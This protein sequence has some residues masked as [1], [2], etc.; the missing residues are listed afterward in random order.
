LRELAR[1]VLQS[2][3]SVLV[4]ATF[5]TRSQRALFLAL[6]RDLKRSCTI[7]ALEAPPEVLRR[8]LSERAEAGAD[9]SDADASIL[10]RQLAIRES[11]S[12][13][14]RPHVVHLDTTRQAQVAARLRQIT[15]EPRPARLGGTYASKH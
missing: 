13:E 2:G 9:A 5:L 6:G 10:E 12:A 1:Q 3:Y 15:A 14:E 8:R 4:D 11:F 7:L